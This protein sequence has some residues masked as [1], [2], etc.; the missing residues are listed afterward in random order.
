M[1]QRYSPCQ[2]YT[3]GDVSWR[4]TRS[5][6]GCLIAD[7]HEMQDYLGQTLVNVDGLNLYGV[8]KISGMLF[9]KHEKTM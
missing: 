5:G 1:T 6:C 8:G 7:S 9:L 4:P 2:R 3:T